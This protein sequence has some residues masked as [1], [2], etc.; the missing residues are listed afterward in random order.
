M[1]PS[2]GSMNLLTQLTELRETRVTSLLKGRIK[3]TY[4]QTRQ[5]KNTQGKIWQGPEGESFCPDRAGVWESPNFGERALG[6]FM[7]ASSIK[8]GG[9]V[10]H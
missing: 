10:N 7:E 8:I 6:I 3:D 5:T 4:E 9:I 2:L 1:A